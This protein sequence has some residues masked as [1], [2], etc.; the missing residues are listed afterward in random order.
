MCP[1]GQKK[2]PDQASKPS[3]PA[4]KKVSEPEETLVETEQGVS[5]T[6]WTCSMS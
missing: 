5:K 1:T 6:H 2:K 4:A 3:K